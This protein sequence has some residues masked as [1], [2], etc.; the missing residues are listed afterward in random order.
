MAIPRIVEMTI[1]LLS[2]Q[3]YDKFVV[4][5]D[6]GFGGA[7]QEHFGIEVGGNK[8]ARIAP[9]HCRHVLVKLL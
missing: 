1:L 5:K 8:K 9:G 2:L 3:E 4:L 6:T 7:C